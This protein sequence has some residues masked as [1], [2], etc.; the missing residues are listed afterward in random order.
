MNKLIKKETLHFLIILILIQSTYAQSIGATPKQTIQLKT[1]T[2]TIADFGI[3]QGSEYPE[4]ITIEGNYDW[5]TVEETDFILEGK[6]GRTIKLNITV[7]KPGTYSA[8]LKICGQPITPDGSSL[9]TK[10]CT[11]HN[12]TVI[13]TLDKKT[14]ILIIAAA[15]ALFILLL[16]SIILLLRISTK[17]KH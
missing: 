1:N 11:R 3:S 15:I 13:A 16:I 14:R 7:K 9:S 8:V 17:H 4:R 2:P 6:S 10:A 12:L 5:L